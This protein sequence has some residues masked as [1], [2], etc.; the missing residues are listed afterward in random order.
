LIVVCYYRYWGGGLW[1]E[2][3]AAA[4]AQIAAFAAEEE[5]AAS[6]QI[7]AFAARWWPAEDH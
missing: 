4:T 6:A 7:A 3:E 1:A 5:A 2:E